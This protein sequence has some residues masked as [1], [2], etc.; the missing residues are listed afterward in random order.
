MKNTSLN[1]VTALE[2]GRM[3]SGFV[4]I[5]AEQSAFGKDITIQLFAFKV[6]DKGYQ[7]SI[8]KYYTG[9][10]EGELS[11]KH[12]RFERVEDLI[13]YV[14]NNFSIAFSTFQVND[15]YVR[16][17]FVVNRQKKG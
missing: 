4:Q 6:A 10:L 7:L 15:R 17:N 13:L 11:K 8:E 14:H 3:V 12:R 16:N 1:P 9:Q 5:P 2:Q